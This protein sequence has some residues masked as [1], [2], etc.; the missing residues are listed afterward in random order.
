MRLVFDPSFD[1]GAYP[2]PDVSAGPVVGEHWVGPHGLLGALETDLGL[3]GPEL[4]VDD[5]VASL[6]PRLAAP[7]AFWSGSFE[8]DPQGTAR[9]L[10]RLRD[11]LVAGGWAFRALTP[12]LA[13]LAE[14]CGDGLSG[15]PDRVWAVID[16]LRPRSTQL[17]SLTLVEPTD[18]LEQVW[19]RL[20]VRLAACGA[21]IARRPLTS[22]LASGDLAAAREADFAPRGDGSLQLLRCYGE[23][24]AADE[25]AAFCASADLG[26][27]LVIQPEACLDDAFARHGVPTLGARDPVARDALVA[28]VGLTLRL[29]WSPADPADALAVLEMRRGPVPG[30]LARALVGALS[31]AP[32]VHGAAFRAAMDTALGAEADPRRRERSRE[33][34]SWLFAEDAS[35]AEDRYPVAAAKLRLKKLRAWLEGVGHAGASDTAAAVDVCRHLSALLEGWPSNTLGSATLAQ[36][37]RDAAASPSGARHEAQAG[38]QTVRGPGAVAGPA[39]TIVWWRFTADAVGQLP[40]LPLLQRDRQALNDAEVVLSD[41]RTVAQA[42]STRWARPLHQ[43]RR[44]LI[45]VSPAGDGGMRAPHPLWDE[46]VARASASSLAS[47][48]GRRLRG[49]TLRQAVAH[50]PWPSPRIEFGVPSAASRLAQPDRLSAS[51]METLLGCSLKWALERVG[52]LHGPKRLP[53]GSRLQGILAHAVLAAVFETRP[54]SETEARER[55]ATHFDRLVKETAAILLLPGY[56]ALCA[57]TKQVCEGAAEDLYRRY[58]DLGRWPI[59]REHRLDRELAGLSLRGDLDVLL[60]DEPTVIDL[61]W[62]SGKI[63]QK[64]LAQGSALQLAVYSVLASESDRPDVPAAYYVL[65]ERRLLSPSGEELAGSHVEP[66]PTLQET[67]DALRASVKEAFGSGALGAGR[68]QAPGA[69]NEKGDQEGIDYGRLRVA[70]PCR[71]CELGALCGRDFQTG[72][73]TP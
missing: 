34:L 53:Q 32:S 43:A 2:G 29:G 66:G 70:P 63:H 9:R 8:V 25:V 33:R 72:E 44:H 71:F 52:R 1:S 24:E 28:L 57:H 3:R 17:R 41:P 11:A 47:I 19:Q 60:G 12:R 18:D 56:D 46:L 10:L 36:L 48:Q 7:G 68:L 58:A 23:L 27:L 4:S 39:D 5:R 61:K 14:V 73:D 64:K 62:A 31:A 22:A 49:A 54:A 65:D 69:R 42:R 6:L 37:L 15:T 40:R 30:A 20:F 38:A 45:L 51:A 67:W 55:A 26:R 59:A 13:Q 35:R 21:E 16:A 50:R